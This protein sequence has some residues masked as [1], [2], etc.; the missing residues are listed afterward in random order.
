MVCTSVELLEVE[1]DELVSWA[2]VL[3]ELLVDWELPELVEL[4]LELDSLLSL[5]DESDELLLE[6]LRLEAEL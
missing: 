4:I 1:S 3:L 2:S 6:V 5:E